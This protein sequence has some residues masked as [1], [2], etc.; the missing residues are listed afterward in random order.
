MEIL[1]ELWKVIEDRKVNP[2]PDSYTNQLLDDQ[3]LI[4]EKLKEELQEIE[5]A[6]KANKLGSEKDGAV[7]EVS[8]FLYHLLVL[9][10]ATGIELDDVLKE[11]KRRR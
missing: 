5:E 3:D 2:K 10:S 9:L 4:F 7:W 1:E 8:D 11:L 6:V